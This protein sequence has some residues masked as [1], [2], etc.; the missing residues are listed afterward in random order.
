[1]VALFKARVGDFAMP[2]HITMWSHRKK[3][4][5][6]MELLQPVIDEL[7]VEVKSPS[8]EN[9]TVFL[10][11]HNRTYKLS[12]PPQ[13]AGQVHNVTVDNTIIRINVPRPTVP[14]KP[15]DEL[16]NYS[17][18]YLRSMMD[19]IVFDK[20]IDAGDVD[21]LAPV[22]KRF[23]PLFIGLTSFRSKYA[24]EMVNFLTKTEW[25]LSNQ[26]SIEVKM[27]SFVN[28]QGKEG[29]N[30]SADMQQEINI[31]KVKNIIRGLG[32]SKTDKAMVR[33]SQA[34]PAIDTLVEGFRASLGLAPSSRPFDHHSKDDSNDRTAVKEVLDKSRPF[35]LSVG[36]KIGLDLKPSPFSNVNK[37]ELN[38][39][40]VR[41]SRRA[42][43]HC[44]LE[45]D[46]DSE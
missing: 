27:R 12:F 31:K 26:E 16:F 40:I 18:G 9:I 44:P 2:Q 45:L 35:F 10:N 42:I 6:L 5:W 3:L 41:N 32:A 1:M 33:S 14:P 20:V 13:L 38:D 4:A 25:M 37:C 19:F 43:Q 34:A 29:R 21:R 24:I 22:M 39:F 11:H 36:R 7:Y 28:L 30:K 17:L 8:T 46:S 15:D 23:I